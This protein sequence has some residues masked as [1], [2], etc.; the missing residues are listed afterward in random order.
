MI[1]TL[2]QLKIDEGFR[3]KPYVDTVGKITIGYGHNLDDNPL[4]EKQAEQ[5]LKDDLELVIREC[6]L[7]PYYSELDP[8]RRSIVL[9]M[10]FNM[11]MP[12]F[13][14]FKKMNAALSAKNYELAAIELL[15]SKAARDLPIRY[16]RLAKIM[17]L[18]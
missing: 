2:E 10:V 12:N 9:Q 6:V 5:I 15:D 13:K 18:G 7:L 16:E 11:G 8:P 4:T 14:G 17:R 1:S 3:G